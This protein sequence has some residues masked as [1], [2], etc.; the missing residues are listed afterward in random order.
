MTAQGFS[1]SPTLLPSAF[2]R[3][4]HSHKIPQIHCAMGH[5]AL[6]YAV[7]AKLLSIS[8]WKKA[9]VIM[10]REKEN[11]NAIKSEKLIEN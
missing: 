4:C 6:L 2:H 10:V 8:T 1:V 11:S 7:H 5:T 9:A 3:E